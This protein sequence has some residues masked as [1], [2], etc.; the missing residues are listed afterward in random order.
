MTLYTAIAG[1]LGIVVGIVLMAGVAAAAMRRLMVVEHPS[2]Y[3]FEETIERI[4]AAVERAEGWVF[5][6]PE[7]HFSDAMIKHGKPFASVDR[8]IVFFLCK[9]HHAQNM[10]N[11]KPEMASIMPCGWAV[12]ERRGRTYL[13][14]M[15]I[16]L[17]AL[18]FKGIVGRTFQAVGKEEE[19]MLTEILK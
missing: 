5:P 14:S 16:P 3:G 9:A 12:Y 11:A 1:I 6:I 13:G 8:L 2:R 18:P 15:K 10:V 19:A 17:M 4:R 7:W